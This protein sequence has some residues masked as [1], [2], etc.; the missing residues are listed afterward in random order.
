MEILGLKNRVCTLSKQYGIAH[1]KSIQWEN[2]VEK[3]KDAVLDGQQERTQIGAACWNLYQIMCH[4]Q[5]SQVQQTV[6]VWFI[7]IHF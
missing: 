2:A 1:N 7:S 5:N 6:A 3:V 4:R